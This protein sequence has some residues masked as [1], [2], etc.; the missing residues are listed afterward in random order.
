VFQI[1]PDE[2]DEVARLVAAQTLWS[3]GQFEECRALLTGLTSAEGLANLGILAF[4]SGSEGEALRQMHSARRCAPND[5]AITRNT[6]LMLF[7]KTATVK[8]GCSIWL[9]ALNYQLDHDASYYEELANTLKLGGSTDPI[10]FLALANWK[11]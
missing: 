6:V 9:T 3:E 10:T 8:N 5:L 1:D 11:R 7:T 4:I 2:S